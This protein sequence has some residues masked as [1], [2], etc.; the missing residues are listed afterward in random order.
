MRVADMSKCE[1][2]YLCGLT[3]VVLAKIVVS[4]IFTMTY[5]VDR[6]KLVYCYAVLSVLSCLGRDCSTIFVFL[7]PCG[8]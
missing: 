5:D 2:N 4:K 1:V 8:F 6:P 3:T 7:L